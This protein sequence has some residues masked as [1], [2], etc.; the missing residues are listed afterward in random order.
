V[1]QYAAGTLVQ[2]RRVR[3]HGSTL[4]DR[5]SID[6]DATFRASTQAFPSN[7]HDQ[8]PSSFISFAA[9]RIENFHQ[10]ILTLVIVN[11]DSARCVD[12]AL[13]HPLV[14]TEGGGRDES[15]VDPVAIGGKRG[16]IALPDPFSS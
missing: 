7:F 4:Q 5:Q 10:I 16:R 6:I 15:G 12:H 11:I 1:V 8:V 13:I 9:S 14:E 2:D 3:A